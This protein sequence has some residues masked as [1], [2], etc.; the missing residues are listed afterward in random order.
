[1]TTPLPTDAAGAVDVRADDE[2]SWLLALDPAVLAVL[3]GVVLLLL[4]VATVVGWVVVRRI[5]RNPLVARARELGV[6]GATAVAAR[7]LPPGPR[8][9]AAEL[10]LDIG[11]ARERL[12]RQVSTAQAA[13]A[14]LGD[15]PGL[16]PSLE[17]EGTRLEQLL[18]QRALAPA[19]TDRSDLEADARRYLDM[20]ADVC[21]AVLEAE[22]AVPAPGQVG[23][24]V[25]DAVSALRAHT[26][27]YRELTSPPGLPPL[28]SPSPSPEP[29]RRDPAQG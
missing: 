6:Q 14:H 22:Q 24:D 17:A 4:L 16:L 8:R 7:R 1:M 19:T 10:Q 2:L 15:V 21:A 9:T 23:A 25:A 27:A 13:G 12:R 28:P 11:R 20:L 26:T 5:R 3:G 18:R 29:S